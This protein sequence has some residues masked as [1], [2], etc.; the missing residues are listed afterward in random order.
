MRRRLA[1]FAAA[2]WYALASAL[3][4]DAADVELRLHHAGGLFDPVPAGF[5][6]PWAERLRRESGGRIVVRIEAGRKPAS[7]LYDRALTDGGPD[8]VWVA[9]GATPDR[10]PRSELFELP[11]LAG[12][13]ETTSRAAWLLLGE[14]LAADFAGM[15][16]VAVHTAGYG[17]LHMRG[18]PVRRLEDLA[19]RAVAV[20]NR[21]AA[22]TVTALGARPVVLPADRMAA[23]LATGT[24]EGALQSWD[25]A[26]N[27]GVLAAA[28]SHTEM[29]AGQNLATSLHV[30]A[31]RTDRLAA[32]PPDLRA[33]LETASGAAA[34]AEA[35]RA[36]DAYD[37]PARVVADNRGHVLITLDPAEVQRWRLVLA[38]VAETWA[39]SGPEARRLHAAAVTAIRRES[40]R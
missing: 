25:S 31:I 23:A 35:G 28:T 11:L 29:P 1:V 27:S 21:L 13:A 36:M 17:V 5:L 39:A 15:T 6:K 30:L 3:P 34:S 33:V 22:A 12:N 14:G 10:F 32:L 20:P 2:V 16:P 9:T 40:G 18:T 19:G 7:D 4:V 26:R 24:V 37:I 8:L 38:G